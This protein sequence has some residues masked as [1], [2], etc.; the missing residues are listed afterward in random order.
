M[1]PRLT[2]SALRF[3]QFAGLIGLGLSVLGWAAVSVQRTTMILDGVA[4]PF[5]RPLSPLDGL[6]FVLDGMKD[7]AVPLFLSAILLAVCEIALR[8]TPRR[9]TRDES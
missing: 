7:A 1:S 3:L 8:L 6:L 9:T 5:G 2:Q 4:G